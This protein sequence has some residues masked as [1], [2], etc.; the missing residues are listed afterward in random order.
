MAP[1]QSRPCDENCMLDKTPLGSIHCQLVAASLV[2]DGTRGTLV[3]VSSAALGSVSMHA[4]LGTEACARLPRRP[5]SH[6]AAMSSVLR[7]TIAVSKQRAGLCASVC[8]RPSYTGQQR[9]QQCYALCTSH[10]TAKE[11]SSVSAINHWTDWHAKPRGSRSTCPCKR[12]HICYSRASIC[13]PSLRRFDTVRLC[14][15]SRVRQS[16][17]LCN[18]F[19]HNSTSLYPHF[20]PPFISRAI[21]RPWV[22][23]QNHLTHPWASAFVSILGLLAD[24]LS[25]IIHLPTPTGFL[26]RY[27]LHWFQGLPLEAG[28]AA[29][30][31]R[32]RFRAPIR[33]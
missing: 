27:S 30:H 6:T 14:I 1:L 20:P 26:R 8:Q 9:Q 24:L 10:A 23:A 32:P 11:T 21:A 17:H 3:Q 28:A 5:K 2:Q 25:S 31:Q 33:G 15:L 13:P 18:R 19:S 4:S 16:A 12:R 29:C 22:A 7:R